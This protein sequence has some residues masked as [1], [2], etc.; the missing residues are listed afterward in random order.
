MC[1]ILIPYDTGVIRHGI[2]K[3]L[4]DAKYVSPAVVSA[5]LHELEGKGSDEGILDRN[6]INS[7]SYCPR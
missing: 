6:D 5:S 1:S 4:D 2:D 7:I 3:L